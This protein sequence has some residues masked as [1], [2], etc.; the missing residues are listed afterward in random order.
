[1]GELKI[2]SVKKILIC[3]DHPFVQA[4]LEIA[5]RKYFPRASELVKVNSGNEALKT[6]KKFSPEIIFLDLGLPDMTGLEVAQKIKDDGLNP[7]IVIVTNS[8][9]LSLLQGLK[10]L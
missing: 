10:K 3:E 5:L 6:L 9:N 2:E 1:M 4:G 8:N 7:K